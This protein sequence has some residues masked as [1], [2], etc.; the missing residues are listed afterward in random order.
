MSANNLNNMTLGWIGAGRMGYPMADRLAKA[1]CDIKVWN[2]TR[3]KAEP[4]IEHGATV[5]NN[6][7]ELAACDIVFSMVS[8]QDDLQHV[9]FGGDGVLSDGASPK[10]VVDC[11]SI[12]EEVSADIRAR[13]AARGTEF[14]ASPVSGNGKCVKA[15]KLSIVSSG[16]EN[17]FRQVEPYLDTIHSGPG[18]RI[19]APRS[20][21]SRDLAVHCIGHDCDAMVA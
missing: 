4:L 19:S 9:L 1:G 12:S 14:I 11:S 21:D 3:S 5:A 17:V 8:T 2:R 13:L 7:A 16:P 10:I 18:G 20:M 6:L 15:G